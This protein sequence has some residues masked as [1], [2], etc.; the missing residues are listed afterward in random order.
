MY[1][2]LPSSNHRSFN[3][4]KLIDFVESNLKNAND[5]LKNIKTFIEIPQIKN[6]LQNNLIFTPMDL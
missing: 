3:N 5:Y 4:T 6:Y 2:S 1:D